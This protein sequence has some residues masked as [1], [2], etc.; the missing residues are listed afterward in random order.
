MNEL[1]FTHEATIK[2]WLRAL[3]LRDIQT[4]SH[5]LRLAELSTAIGNKLGI[6]EDDLKHLRHSVLLHNIG[7]IGIP[8]LILNKSGP[9]SEKEKKMME[10]HPEIGKD[11]LAP[12][13]F[14]QPAADVAYCHHE[15]WDGSGYPRGLQG[16]DIPLM[17]R[18]ASVCNVW[19]ALTSNQPYRKAWTEVEARIYIDL[20][21]GYQFDP[22]IVDAFLQYIMEKTYH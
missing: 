13:P 16:E 20:G 17:A 3:E 5:S 21:S 22:E 1:E 6:D 14:L 7:K 11:M 19:D 4:E 12:I 9:L 10:L 15:H 8:D 18:I 2:N